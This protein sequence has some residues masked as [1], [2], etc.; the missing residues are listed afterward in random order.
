V[1]HHIGKPLKQGSIDGRRAI[2]IVNPLENRFLL[3]LLSR[4]RADPGR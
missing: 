4:R 2:S 3:A 1:N